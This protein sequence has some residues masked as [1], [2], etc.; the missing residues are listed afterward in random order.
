LE[1]KY[2]AAYDERFRTR[3]RVSG[4][5][6]H[7]AFVP[8]A[9]AALVCGLSICKPIRRRLARATRGETEDAEARTK[10]GRAFSARAE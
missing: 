4:W 10:H 9:A 2:R 7:A 5:L 6:R 3:L 1:W 8:G